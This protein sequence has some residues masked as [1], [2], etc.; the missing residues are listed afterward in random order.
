MAN[1]YPVVPDTENHFE[2]YQSDKESQHSD[3]THIEESTKELLISKYATNS[4]KEAN[5]QI[6]LQ[7][8]AHILATGAIRAAQKQKAACNEPQKETHDSISPMSGCRI[9]GEIQCE[10]VPQTPPKKT[11]KA[12]KSSRPGKRNTVKA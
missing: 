5:A 12:A 1:R 7:Q 2:A 10:D 11:L 9:S 4:Q 3:G 8:A 6:R